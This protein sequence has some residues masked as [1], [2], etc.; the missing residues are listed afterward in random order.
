MAEARIKTRLFPEFRRQLVAN[1][2]AMDTIPDTSLSRYLRGELPQVFV[3]FVEYPELLLA[4]YKDAQA[5]TEDEKTEFLRSFELRSKERK[6]YL[7]KRRR[8]KKKA[9]T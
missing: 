4:L 5:M 9:V 6:D 2:T 7:E 1:A 8:T 3:W